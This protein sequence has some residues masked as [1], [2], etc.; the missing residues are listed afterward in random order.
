MRGRCGLLVHQ[1]SFTGIFKQT[2]FQTSLLNSNDLRNK[3]TEVIREIT[4][5]MS[6]RICG[7]DRILVDICTSSHNEM[8]LEEL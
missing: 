8:E 6:Y 4:T 5:D 2:V 3:N 7:H 1:T